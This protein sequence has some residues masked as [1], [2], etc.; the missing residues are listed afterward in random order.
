MNVWQCLYEGKSDEIVSVKS[1]VFYFRVY[2]RITIY[3]VIMHAW[4]AMHCKPCYDISFLCLCVSNL[5]R[6]CWQRRNNS[7]LHRNMGNSYRW[8]CL[9]FRVHLYNAHSWGWKFPIGKSLYLLMLNN[10][11][12]WGIWLISQWAWMIKC[13]M[14]WALYALSTW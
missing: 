5:G 2:Y 1:G 6:G 8:Y 14:K 3:S 9:T 10:K 12:M 13:F 7:I 11:W 4:E